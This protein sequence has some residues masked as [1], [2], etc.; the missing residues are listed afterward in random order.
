MSKLLHALSLLI[1]LMLY[2]MLAPVAIPGNYAGN[3]S[4]NSQLYLTVAETG[5][6]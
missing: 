1:A 5:L 2:R 6:D 3:F 4:T